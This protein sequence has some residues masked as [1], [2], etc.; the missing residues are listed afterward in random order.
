MTEEAKNALYHR[1]RWCRYFNNGCCTKLSEEFE[2]PIENIESEIEYAMGDGELVEPLQEVLDE[3]RPKFSEELQQN[4]EKWQ[5]FSDE[6]IAKIE[7]AVKTLSHS[8]KE[9]MRLSLKTTIPNFIVNILNKE[10]L[11]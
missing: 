4:D 5:D 7:R 8:M 10:Y 9:L 6:L 11:K 2:K 1:C 3:V